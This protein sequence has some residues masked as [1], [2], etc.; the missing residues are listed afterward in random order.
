MQAVNDYLATLFSLEG[1]T[2]L[3][4]GGGGGVGLMITRA[5][6]SAGAKAFIASRKLETCQAAAE[7]LGDL[8][9]SC[10]AM[11]CDLQTEEGVNQLAESIGERSDGLDI[12]VNNSGR[13]W[14]APLAQF[15]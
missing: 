9:G 11:Q 10:E 14:G 4:T 2:A 8:P 15:P 3:V 12:L 13:S 5:L 1:K 7:S 6:V